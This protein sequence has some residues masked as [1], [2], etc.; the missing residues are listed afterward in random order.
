MIAHGYGLIQYG[1]PKLIFSNVVWGYL[2]H[3]L[4]TIHGILGYS[5][6]TLGIIVLIGAVLFYI[7]RIIGYGYVVSLLVLILVLGRPILFPQF[8]VNSGLLMVG[9][10]ACWHL[11][12]LKENWKTLF[13]GCVLAWLSY[14]I[15]SQEALLVFAV[16]LPFFPW[17]NFLSYRA[18]KIAFL[19]LISFIALSTVIDRQSYQSEEWTNFREVN[20]A[21]APYTDFGTGA[22]LLK[23]PDIYKKYGYSAND[24]ILISGWTVYADP[25]L[26]D[27]NKLNAM[28]AELG[29]LPDQEIAFSNA[30][31]GIM[32]LF[33]S[34]IL[35]ISL[36]ALIFFVL[37]PSR[38][39]ASVWLLC[40]AA[41][42]I[43]GLLGRPGI[44]RVYFP[45]VCLLLIASFFQRR[46]PKWKNQLAAGAILVALVIN[47]YNII[48]QSITILE[49]ESQIR[50]QLMDFP[51]SPIVVLGGGFPYVAAY[52][53]LGA[54][55]AAMNYRFYGLGVFAPA[56]FSVVSVEDKNGRSMKNLFLTDEGVPIIAGE[57]A[58]LVLQTYCK[59]RFHGDFKI[60]RTQQY[61]Q[62][63]VHW[64]K[65][66][67]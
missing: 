62:S 9:A 15:R 60:Q 25:K 1:S 44:L 13:T 34:D 24:I 45:L 55:V 64:L 36:L 47:S 32:A 43:M 11:Y 7:L 16:A 51:D 41:A 48:K 42:F 50:A 14:L 56:P 49:N 46:D 33:H 40:I 65:C 37:R 3:S 61:G 39:L 63:Q 2:I 4:P 23:R 19:I 54:S 5:L 8:T 29:P 21:R 6:A 66:S 59:E 20:L 52:P 18:P 17:R 31:I 27:P 22:L 35:P 30:W 28:R 57:Q 12:S 58:I 67:V 10:V 26:A 53:I 38:R